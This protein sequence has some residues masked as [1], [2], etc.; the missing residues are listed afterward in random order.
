MANMDNIDYALKI[1]CGE[2]SQFS[3]L[4]MELYTNLM[5]TQ[6]KNLLT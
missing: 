4:C 5:Q 3:K 1:Q 2:K 6:G